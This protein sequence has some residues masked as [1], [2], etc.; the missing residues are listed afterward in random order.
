MAL[1]AQATTF[2]RGWQLR[3][4][5][6]FFTG[7]FLNGARRGLAVLLKLAADKCPCGLRSPPPFPHKNPPTTTTPRK[8]LCSAA[9]RSIADRLDSIN[10]QFEASQNN[11]APNW[12]RHVKKEREGVSANGNNSYR[13][14][15]R[16]TP[17]V[18]FSFSISE[19]TLGVIHPLEP[20]TSG[21]PTK[22]RLAPNLQPTTTRTRTAPTCDKHPRDKHPLAKEQRRNGPHARRLPN[23]GG[24]GSAAADESTSADIRRVSR[25][26]DAAA[27]TA[28]R[29]DGAD[30]WRPQCLPR[31]RERG[32]E[33]ENR[34][35]ESRFLAARL[36][37]KEGG[38]E[39]LDR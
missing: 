16:L 35:G 13:L 29:V 3:D 37:A 9:K 5:R 28:A 2:D 15:R 18:F 23:A 17:A 14:V 21:S 4:P 27:P 11:D 8:E 20:D 25:P 10:R 19:P 36:G 26:R 12:R 6:S 7:T 34:K 31:R 24:G 39:G 38:R 32:E 22:P 1:R 33:K 30:V